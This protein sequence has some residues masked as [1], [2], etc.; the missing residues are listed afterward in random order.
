MEK[1]DYW[2]MLCTAEGIYQT[3]IDRLLKDFSGPEEIYSLTDSELRRLTCIERKKIEA[4]ISSRKPGKAEEIQNKLDK[5]NIR[6]ICRDDEE[7]P[8]G[9]R[10]LDG[11]PYSLYVKGNLPSIEEP[12]VGMVGARACSGYGRAKAAEISSKL[13]SCGVQIVSGMAVGIDAIS[14]RAALEAGGK[15][16]AVLGC[17]VDV[18]YPKDNISLYYDILMHGGGVISEYPPGTPPVAWQFPH[19]NRLISALSDRLVVIE[20]GSRSG[21]LSTARHA[22]DQGREVYALPG[23]TI[24]RLSE[25]CNRLIYDGAGVFLD[26]DHFVSDLYASP[27]WERCGQ[28][29]THPAQDQNK[30]DIISAGMNSECRKV[31]SHFGI[32]PIDSDTISKA[33]GM[34]IDKVQACLS[35]MEIDGLILRLPGGYYSKNFASGN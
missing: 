20:A 3:D 14:A 21:T 27:R 13:A 25:G 35:E 22:L 17:G 19:R 6:F 9:F 10:M 26:T 11:M 31:F 32:S 33:S 7:Y 12:S 2:F 24:D 15:T 29:M 16:F 30:D 18:I 1:R 34:S 8:L 23:R 28:S 4:V 5:D